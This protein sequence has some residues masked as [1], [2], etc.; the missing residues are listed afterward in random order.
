VQQRIIAGDLEHRRQAHAAQD[1][2]DV[3]VGRD[4]GRPP[5][6]LVDA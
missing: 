6:R 5:A 1:I 2:G 3:V 4:D